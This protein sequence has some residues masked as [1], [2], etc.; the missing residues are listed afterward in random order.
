MEINN[1]S[2]NIL[3]SRLKVAGYIET[4]VASNSIDYPKDAKEQT[5]LIK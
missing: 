4:I 5:K 3:S 1:K 2:M